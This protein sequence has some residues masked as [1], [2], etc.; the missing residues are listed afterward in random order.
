[1][2]S[3]VGLMYQFYN[4]ELKA[5]VFAKSGKIS[6]EELPA[7]TQLFTPDWIVHYMVE[8][9]LGR[10]WNEGHPND[11][12][13]S[14]WMYY[15]AEVEQEPDV[16]SQLKKIC[17]EYKNIIPEA[18]KVIDPC[19]GSGHILVC[20]FDVLMQIYESQG[21]TQRD[22]AQSIM[23][24]NLFG[25]DIDK[26]ATQLAYFAIMMKAR[27]YD[28]RIFGRN[29]RPNIY[30][31]EESNYINQAQLKYFGTHM[32]SEE[33]SKAKREL[34]DLIGRF[35]DA[36]EYGSILNIANH[37]WI[38][39]ERFVSDLNTDGQLSFET[40]GI[41]ETQK[42]LQQLI[43]QGKIMTQ[44][45]DVV[46]TNPP[47]MSVSSGSALL[48]KYVKDNYPDSKTDLFAVFIEKCKQLT[49]KNGYQAMITM[50]S[51]MFLSSYE[52]LRAKML[53]YDLI[54]MAHLGAR[55]FEEIAGEV[56]QTTTFVMRNSYVKDYRG[57][58][59][60]LVSGT[61]QSD[62]ERLY[63]E[64]EHQYYASAELFDV[65]PG[66]A[67]AYWISNNLRSVFERGVLLSKIASPKQGMATADNNRF[68]RKWYE[69]LYG[70]ISFN[71][72]PNYKWF[73]YNN[74]GGYRK[75]YGFNTDVVN[76]ENDGAA[77]K[78]YPKAYVRNEK[79]Y[80]KEGITW[81]ALGSSAISARYFG[82]GYIFSNAGMAV[83]TESR[84]LK[85]L[86]AFINSVVANKVLEVTSPTLNFNAGDIANLPLLFEKNRTEEII[87]LANECIDISKRDWDSF[88]VSWEFERHPLAVGSRVSDAYK[89]WEIDCNNRVH[90][91]ILTEEKLNCV[92]AEMYGL[93][94]ELDLTVSEGSIVI[95]R[96]DLARDIKSLI[97]YAVGCM[98]GRYSIDKPGLVFA[99]GDWD[100][101]N[102]ISFIPDKDNC[103]PITDEEY[104]EDDIV[105][106]FCVWLKKVYGDETLEEN[107]AFIA[108]ALGNKG[109]T[110][111]DVI[112]NYF[113]NDFI[114]DHIK[115]YQKRPI[116]WLFDSGK[117][118][119]FKALVYMH[120]WNADT[121]GNLRVEYLHRM[122]RVY[123]SEINRMQEI[124]NN[125]SDSREVFKASKRK[126]KLQK[127][128]REAQSYDGQI[129]H[130]ALSR[131]SIDAN[132]GVKA[133]Y[134]LVQRDRNG[135]VLTL[136]YK[137]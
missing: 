60:R 25:L 30:T 59:S 17:A 118:N 92:F 4:I 93:E 50:H 128:L 101:G 134:D 87:S 19:M 77:I 103:I 47:Y 111:R 16:V 119:G 53:S 78:A 126:E 121:V 99:G 1:M 67:I 86:L 31:I 97:S 80:F 109:K 55:A 84:N 49:K 122:Q 68:V 43:A 113:L 63:L 117:Q 64:Q 71:F 35:L 76:W 40:I 98:F 132:D 48:N 79:D 137:L 7:A 96:P 5:E 22:A 105:G 44:K 51:W 91:L 89:Q 112:R 100:N 102:Y 26:R 125:S 123:E 75:W 70:D 57:T 82:E 18:I 3:S 62:K 110:S 131:V 11:E 116:Y 15:Q 72:G 124:N 61:S 127:Q 56:V 33:S 14:N 74:G 45:Y 46:C 10:L 6:K 20:C 133:N 83:F 24:N 114:K 135:K 37:D 129:A 23:E 73:P 27:Q 52:K 106:L 130:I 12:L 85:V 39:L 41:E 88:E 9:S 94:D 65:I 107:L 58:Y 90:N 42:R 29:I 13:K 54:S 36:K 95:R 115:T 81:N 108:K 120:R 136:L 38:L 8:N 32:S 2:K 69:V 21:Y 66:R 104:F 28:R 34:T